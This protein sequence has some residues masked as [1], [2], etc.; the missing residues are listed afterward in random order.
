MGFVAKMFGGGDM[1]SLPPQ[2]DYAAIDAAN[3]E[4]T[5]AASDAQQATM[6][7]GRSSTMLTGGQGLGTDASTTSKKLL[8]A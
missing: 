5:Q 7:R 1:P 3:K 2:P 6:M 8:G 4:K